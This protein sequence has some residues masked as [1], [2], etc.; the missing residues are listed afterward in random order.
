MRA[1]SAQRE[2]ELQKFWETNRVYQQLLETN[3]GVRASWSAL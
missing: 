3:Q 2:P 1:N